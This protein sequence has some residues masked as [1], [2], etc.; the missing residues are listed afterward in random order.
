MPNSYLE[1][2]QQ[3]LRQGKTEPSTYLLLQMAQQAGGAGGQVARQTSQILEQLLEEF[4]IEPV[5]RFF[6]EM[7]TTLP[8][9]MTAIIA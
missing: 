8:D 3:Y 9:E 6:S 2:L 5:C 7:R 1:T 4:V